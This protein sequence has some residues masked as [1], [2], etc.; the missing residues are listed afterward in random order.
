MSPRPFSR[1]GLHRLECN[2]GA[3]VYAVLASLESH[4]LPSC[5]CGERFTPTRREVA[6]VLGVSCPAI[7]E[8]ET[9]KALGLTDAQAARWVEQ[10]RREKAKARRLAALR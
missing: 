7:T 1:Q 10:Q 3:Y 2:C 4:G 9:A 8:F 5:A 6:L